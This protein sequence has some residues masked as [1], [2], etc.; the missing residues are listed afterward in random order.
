MAFRP[1]KPPREIPCNY[2]NYFK[3]LVYPLLASP[4][5]DGIR[6]VSFGG[7]MFSSTMKHIPSIHIQKRFTDVDFGDYEI[8]VGNPTDHNFY[9]NTQSHVTSVDKDGDFRCYVIDYFENTSRP[10]YKRYDDV[11]ALNLDAQ[12]FE[13]LPQIEIAN[14]D[15]LLILEKEYLEKG[16]EGLV[17][18]NPL[19]IYKEHARCTIREQIIWKLKRYVDDE[20]IV[21]DIEEG[22]VNNNEA[23]INEMGLQFRSSSQ[24]GKSRSGMAG[25]FLCLYNNQEITVGMGKFD[26]KERVDL[27]ENKHKYEGKLLKVRFFNYGIKDKPRQPIALGWRSKI[28]L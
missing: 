15:E 10:F 23:E 6:G 11:L 1:M 17:L 7:T 21:I 25:R 27:L 28:D 18:R 5:I 16:Y 14:E 9:N 4:K 20:V 24:D 19:G 8:G 22:F 26:H 13:V 2:P 3:S 12:R